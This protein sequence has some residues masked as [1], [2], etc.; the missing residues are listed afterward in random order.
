[1]ALTERLQDT[2]DVGYW[3]GEIPLEYIY[4]YGRAGEKYFRHL[5]D[6]GNLLGTRCEACD[7]VYVPPRVYCEKCLARLEDSYVEVGLEGVVH[8]YTILYKNLDGFRKQEPAVLAMIN[9][10]D[11]DGGVVHFLGEVKPDDVFIGM[12]VEAVLKPKEE[13][14]GGI[15]DIKY[16]KP[17]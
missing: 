15:L 17:M 11:T 13:R 4:T 8:T 3:T 6:K 5:M 12:P 7:V 16:F 14:T 1:M 10:G 2:R 9:I